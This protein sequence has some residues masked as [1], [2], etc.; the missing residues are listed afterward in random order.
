MSMT[1]PPVGDDHTYD[2]SEDEDEEEEEK[3]HEQAAPQVTVTSFLA[4]TNQTLGK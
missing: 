4:S 1:G 3:E 2:P